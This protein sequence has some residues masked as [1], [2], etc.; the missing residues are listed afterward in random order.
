MDS[1]LKSVNVNRESPPLQVLE[2]VSDAGQDWSTYG[3]EHP[4]SEEMTG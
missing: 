2:Y 3:E 4:G 1:T